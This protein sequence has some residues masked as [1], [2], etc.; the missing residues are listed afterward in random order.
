MNERTQISGKDSGILKYT[1]ITRKYS[2]PKLCLSQH[3]AQDSNNTVKR[4]VTVIFVFSSFIEI[5][6]AYSKFLIFKIQKLIS[7]DFV[8]IHETI[9]KLKNNMNIKLKS[10]FEHFCYSFPSSHTLI[11]PYSSSFCHH[12]LV[13][14]CYNFIKIESYS[15]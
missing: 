10:F 13:C 9:I 3:R 2:I 4:L 14:I 15:I 1:F 5:W 6:L 7:F 12:T 11:L 8:C